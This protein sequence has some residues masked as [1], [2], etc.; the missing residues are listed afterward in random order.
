MLTRSKGA[1]DEDA[2][3]ADRL[4]VLLLEQSRTL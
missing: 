4:H 3:G 1:E 2:L